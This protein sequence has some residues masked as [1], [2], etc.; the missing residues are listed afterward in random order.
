MPQSSPKLLIA[1]IGQ[2]PTATAT[3][4][5]YPALRYCSCAQRNRRSAFA[6][7]STSALVRGCCRL[8]K[9]GGS[10]ARRSGVA[11]RV[12]KPKPVQCARQ[13][14]RTSSE[15]LCLATSRRST[16]RTWQRCERLRFSP[17][18]T[19]YHLEGL[20][21]GSAHCGSLWLRCAAAPFNPTDPI[22]SDPVTVMAAVLT[23]THSGRLSCSSRIASAPTTDVRRS[24]ALWSATVRPS[25]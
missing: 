22:R 13:R 4:T 7:Q 9:S 1:A 16:W 11:H 19:R 18:E 3:A 23:Y 15:T 8:R 2:R 5:A 6:E 10:P 20:T 25:D 17:L 12:T 21:G 24:A 14:T